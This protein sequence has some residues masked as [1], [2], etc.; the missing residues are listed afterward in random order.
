[1][2]KTYNVQVGDLVI[3]NSDQIICFDA[4]NEFDPMVWVSYGTTGSQSP[5]YDR[6]L[7]VVGMDTTTDINPIDLFTGKKCEWGLHMFMTYEEFMCE[8]NRI[9]FFMNRDPNYLKKLTYDLS[10]ENLHKLNDL[11]RIQTINAVIHQVNL[12]FEGI[13]SGEILIPLKIKSV[14]S[15]HTN[16]LLHNIAELTPFDV[17]TPSEL[18]Q[19]EQSR[20][21]DD[22]FKEAAQKIKD[23]KEQERRDTLN[24]EF[25]SAMDSYDD[26]VASQIFEV[27]EDE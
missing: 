10:H 27:G 21:N 6:N 1:M 5:I 16:T 3:R 20:K 23:M 9:R 18:E 4:G 2:D 17:P 26:D 14:L 12:F 8:Y 19:I 22:F 11:C 15:E 25:E 24:A 13:E 7:D